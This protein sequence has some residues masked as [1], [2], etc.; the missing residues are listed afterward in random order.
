M[1]VAG[2]DADG[3]YYRL[4]SGT[5]DVNGPMSVSLDTESDP[6][7][8]EYLIAELPAGD[9]NLQLQPGWW[10]EQWDP[11]SNTTIPVAAWLLSEN[12]IDTNV[13][14][15]STT[16][17]TYTF[18]VE[19]VGPINLADGN[20]AVDV[21]F[22]TNPLAC[23]PIAQDCP[24]GLSCFLSDM[25]TGEFVCGPEGGFAQYSECYNTFDCQM[26]HACLPVAQNNNCTFGIDCC[27]PV[28]DL[29]APAC[30][31]GET[32]VAVDATT[33]ICSTN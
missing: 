10:V 32:C 1:G 17:V 3:N 27:I 24:N 6:S 18:Y 25:A 15:F 7:T 4:R 13:G 16:T 33:G 14:E 19:G 8:T 26:D 12:P 20:L 11:F 2:Q 5:I 23:D 31:F 28:C 22:D 21:E 30:P 29:A 9:Y